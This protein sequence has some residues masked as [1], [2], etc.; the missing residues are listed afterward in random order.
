MNDNHAE[1]FSPAALL[2]RPAQAA[3]TL[4]GGA[5]DFATLFLGLA[6]GVALTLAALRHASLGAD[7]GAWDAFFISVLLAPLT[8][9]ALLRLATRV[10]MYTLGPGTR[11][12][13][14]P[15]TLAELFAWCLLPVL[16]AFAL[17][18]MP[19]LGTGM[20]WFDGPRVPF[21]GAGATGWALALI[22]L[23]AAAWSL[24]AM[25]G[26]AAARFAVSKASATLLVSSTIA[27]L[28]IAYA[29]LVV[30]LS[31]MIG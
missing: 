5:T 17:A 20:T 21:W 1:P 8:G 7:L 2:L 16:G 15:G 19:M 24:W 3:P 31:A 29:L 25:I 14:P 4:H 28:C 10:A 30:L 26:A 18:S 27:V 9:Y 6:F 22:A 12:Q 13:H 11:S 23:L